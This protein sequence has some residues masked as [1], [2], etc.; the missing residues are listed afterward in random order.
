MLM[1]FIE[2]PPVYTMLAGLSLLY[3]VAAIV[4]LVLENRS[5][6]ST[7]AWLFLFLIF[8]LGGLLIY[9]LF[10]R[11]RHAFSDEN[12]LLKQEIERHLPNAMLSHLPEQDKAMERLRRDIPPSF[13]KLLILLEDN[14][15]AYLTFHNQLE[16]LQ[17]A[18]QKYPRLVEDIRAAQQSIHLAYF[19]WGSDPF[20]ETLKQILIAKARAGV[21]VRVL[22][23]PVGSFFILRWRY[24]R[25][26]NAGGVKMV[27]FSPIYKLHTISYRNHRKIAVIDG[28]IGYTGGLNMS[29]E[30]LSGPKGFT[31]WRDTHMRLTGEAVRILQAIFL[32]TWYN[33]TGEALS[34][35]YYYYPTVADE[36]ARYLP[37][38][39][40]NSGPDSEWL[41]IRQLYFFLIL[42]AER[43]VYIQSPFFILDESLSEA[44]KAAALSGVQVK[45]MLAPA[46]AEGQLA[47]RAGRTYAAAMVKAGV[48]VY[49]YYGDYFHAK[50]IM[51]DS[52]V[53]S[54]GSANMDIRSFS[55]NYETNLV[56]Y[57][58]ATT[59]QL[60]QD[61]ENDLHHCTEF[62]PTAYKKQIAVRLVDSTARL[63]SPLL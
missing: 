61:F 3:A 58:E 63:F 29:E 28:Q 60:E 15:Y 18:R 13:R 22:F 37:V 11:G 32:T 38:Q 39:V 5:P 41:A 1:F 35:E 42:A 53:C 20:T 54:I 57:D 19:E 14:A 50:T 59:R 2:M 34:S 26:M 8:P 43:H 45:V 4:F 55:I 16:I 9:T 27:P 12:K 17:N 56:M 25:E 21:E 33:G 40:I 10:G 36:T 52:A 48:Q 46:G 44:L 49:Y 62:S 30:H 6:Q 24:V 51:V 7:F 47:Y 23:D 31:G